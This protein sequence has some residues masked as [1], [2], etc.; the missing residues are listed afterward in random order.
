MVWLAGG[1]KGLACIATI[2]LSQ[3]SE[4][5][6]VICS[7]GLKYGD[8]KED[9][10]AILIYTFA[11]LGILS[12]Y[13]ITY[14][15]RLYGIISWVCRRLS[16]RN[17][18]CKPLDDDATCKDDDEDDLHPDHDIVILG[19]HK[20]A[21]MLIAHLEHYNPRL[22]ARLHVIDYHEDI[23]AN[24]KQRGVT[25]AYGDISSPDVLQHAHHG[26]VR[27]VISSIPDNLLR[28]VTNLR[29]LQISK[30]LWPEADIIA[31]ATTPAEVR[32]LYAEGAEYVLRITKLCA[33]KLAE[34]I[35]DHSTQTQ[36]SNAFAHHREQDNKR[37]V[38]GTHSSDKFRKPSPDEI[39][40]FEDS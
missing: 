25:C 13:F 27:L 36:F 8:V 2:N 29:L 33:E 7:L 34:L 12:Q 35:L 31:T 26:D 38:H 5:A 28:G 6:L 3:I 30:Q 20:S 40:R 22:L 1:G 23:M 9:T 15:Y 24:L 17:R 19:F 37:P 4:F 10:L 14:N 18:R 39:M 16:C 32:K 21:A 11:F